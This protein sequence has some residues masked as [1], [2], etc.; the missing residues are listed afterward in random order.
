M[1]SVKNDLST[2]D[3]IIFNVVSF[4]SGG[5]QL[6]EAQTMPLPR[7]FLAEYHATRIAEKSK[8]GRAHG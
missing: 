3:E 5:I 2:L 6:G 4:Y 8:K 7:L 1:C